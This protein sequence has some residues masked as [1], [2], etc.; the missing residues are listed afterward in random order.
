MVTF[1]II[2][3]VIWIK[4]GKSRGTAFSFD[5]GDRR[6]F[7]TA[8]HVVKSLKPKGNIQIYQDKTWRNI[9]V[10]LIEHA[11]QPIDITVFSAYEKITV[12]HAIDESK[13]YYCG[14]NVFFLG[15]PYGLHTDY[16]EYGLEFPVPI[17]KS[18]FISAVQ[19]NSSS[20]V[21]LLDG[22]NNPGFSGSP[23]VK[24]NN[25]NME[26]ISVVT[27]HKIRKSKLFVKNTE[28]NHFIWEN[29]GIIISYSFSHARDIM[30]RN[31]DKGYLL[32]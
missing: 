28:T 3:R 17:L 5:I 27:A 8:Q 13:L 10:Q 20:C 21:V 25:G 22:H 4:Y 12:D 1:N 7:V 19:K 6:F 29:T 23:V 15:F 30:L 18:A 14:E 26:I 11:K 16:L 24:N 31:I 32:K 9:E 2:E